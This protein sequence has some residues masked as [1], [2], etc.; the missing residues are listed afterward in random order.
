M[1]RAWL[2]LL[3]TACVSRTAAAQ[4][5]PCA[6]AS[7]ARP[8]GPLQVGQLDGL[9]AVPHRACP[10]MELAIGGDFLLVADADDLYGNI[11]ANG[12]VRGSV[13]A[14]DDQ[15]EAF[16]SWEP[17]RYQTIVGAVSASYLGLGY[18]SFGVSGQLLK[19][20]RGVLAVTSRFVAP[21]TTGLDQGSFPLA[22]DVGLTAAHRVH[23]AVRVHGWL[24]LLGTVGVGGP[25]EPHA[26]TR[27]GFG[28]D[29]ALA[30]A[31]SIVVEAVTGIASADAIDLFAAQLGFRFGFSDEVG[32][33]LGLSMP[34]IG[35][36]GVT[37]GALPLAAS[38]MVNWHLP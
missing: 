12:R 31:F 5:D 33:E 18:L 11:R 8:I 32:L 35:A 15:L 36:R 16:V 20:G 10:R 23:D 6:P 25:S 29:W 13:A 14:L 19:E 17:I 38:S 28:V 9:L 30:P 4:D 24:N 27:L 3:L 1:K 7:R 37:A 26:G 21:T 2:I 34:I 22:L